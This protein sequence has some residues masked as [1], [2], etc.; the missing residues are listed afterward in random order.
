MGGFN[1]SLVSV[2]LGLVSQN[3]VRIDGCWVLGVQMS[4]VKA[5]YRGI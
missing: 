4:R 3:V 2:G 5:V 1:G